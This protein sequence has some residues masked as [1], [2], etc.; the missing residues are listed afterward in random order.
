MTQLRVVLATPWVAALL[1]FLLGVLLI[2]AGLL[3]RRAQEARRFGAMT[4][5]LE[6]EAAAG[7]LD[8]L[9]SYLTAMGLDLGDAR[10]A[11]LAKKVVGSLSVESDPAGATVAGP[12]QTNPA[13]EAN[14]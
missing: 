11:G 7:H 10:L 6:S 13:G 3:I 5:R 4:A 2:A 1:G 8:E 12:N 14:Q 9:S